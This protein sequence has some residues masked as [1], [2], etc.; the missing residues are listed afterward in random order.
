MSGN[1]NETPWLSGGLTFTEDV[2]NAVIEDA[3]TCYPD[4]SCGFVAGPGSVPL[5]CDQVFREENEA[6]KYNDLDPERFPRRGDTYFKINELRASR[7]FDSCADQ[8]TPIKV[9]Y[10][11]HC[12]AGAYFSEEDAATFAHG[13]QLT[14]PVAFLVTSVEDG[15]FNDQKLWVFNGT[16]FVEA[17]F[18]VLP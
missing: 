2:I 7:L 9:I 5:H 3:I 14:W 17:N 15:T 13:G 8:G 4:E 1:A 6:N 12:D 11:S 10:H 18:S 16:T